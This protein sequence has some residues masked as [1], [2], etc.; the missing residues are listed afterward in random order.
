[1]AKD[2]TKQT[3]GYVLHELFR[4]V[5]ALQAA[6]SGVMDGVH[7]KTGLSTSQR[8]IMN[9]LDRMEAVTVPEMAARLG[10][11]RQFIQTVCNDLLSRGFLS[12]A[13]NPRHKRSKLAALTDDGRAVF[14]SSQQKENMIIEQALPDID[15]SRAKDAHALLQRIR[16]EVQNISAGHH[17]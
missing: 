4:E 3:K 10:V 15:L 9:M 6:L 14:R 13:D 5:F 16:K 2:S 17:A 7:E 12:F 8:K 1:M 11:S